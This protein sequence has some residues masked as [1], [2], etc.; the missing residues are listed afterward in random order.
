MSSRAPFNIE[1]GS[2]AGARMTIGTSE[3]RPAHDDTKVTASKTPSQRSIHRW[4]LATLTL[5][6]LLFGN[7]ATFAQSVLDRPDRHAST[8]AQDQPPHIEPTTPRDQRPAD[9]GPSDDFTSTPLGSS[10]ST[11]ARSPA[12]GDSESNSANSG[13]TNRS[14]THTG[15]TNQG[16]TALGSSDA[17][18]APANRAAPVIE[19]S[20]NWVERAQIWVHQTQRDLHRKITHGV[21]AVARD[22][23][24]A[25]QWS[26]IVV[27]F[28]YGIFHA[29]GPG[30]GKV[31]ISAYL[32][33]HRERLARGLM[34]SFA[35][36]MLQGI[37]AIALV[38]IGLLALGWLVRDVTGQVRHL[39][40]AS[41]TLIGLIG[42]WLT[43]RG[44]RS[45]LTRQQHSK[46]NHAQ[47]PPSVDNHAR[48]HDHAH[49]HE[50]EHEH[51]HRHQGCGC[52][53]PHHVDPEARGPWWAL[54]LSVGIRPCSGAVLLMSVAGLMGL[55]WTGVI[56]VLLMSLGTAM[57]V[58]T[59]ATLAVF[60]RATVFRVLDSPLGANRLGIILNVAAMLAGVL[61]AWLGFGLAW[62]LWQAPPIN[63]PLMR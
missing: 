16:I 44:L 17:N 50:H 60:A 14:G 54:V 40:L 45:L 52:G 3:R 18:K 35:A 30:H 55:W 11:R 63:H 51:E 42:L 47:V 10:N 39:E 37:V 49:Q 61:I 59:L 13:P 6:L 1:A 29:I 20:P 22:P 12:D 57:T 32:M 48:G 46:A 34:L 27:A 15:L 41:F 28:L 33:T 56:A 53:R 26:L 7:P 31:V 58:A 2:E 24:P 23:G 38:V 21:Q 5:L 25:A 43:L 9:V 19:T 4:A 62:S 36:S 8:A